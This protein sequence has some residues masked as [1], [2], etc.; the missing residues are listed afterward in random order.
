MRSSL[1]IVFGRLRD[2][3]PDHS[4]YYPYSWLNNPGQLLLF[5]LAKSVYFETTDH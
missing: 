5:G 1:L 4:Q 2:A 3:R